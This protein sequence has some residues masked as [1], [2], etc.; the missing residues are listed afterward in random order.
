LSNAVGGVIQGF[1]TLN[2][3]VTNLG[4][5]IATNGTLVINNANSAIIQQAGTLTL[6]SG[7]TLTVIGGQGNGSGQNFNN[8]GQILAAG[9][10][11]SATNTDGLVNTG[12]I[13]GFGTISMGRLSGSGGA[14]NEII[15]AGGTIVATN[16]TLFLNPGDAFANGGFS[17]GV[18][19]TALIANGATLTLN[20]TANAWNNSGLNPRNRGTITLAGGSFVLFSDG[21]ADPSR[22]IDNIDGRISGFGTISG[23]ISNFNAATIRASGGVLDLAGTGKFYQ[24]GTLQVD[25]GATMLF[26]NSV[27]GLRSISNSGTIFMNGG[28]LTAGTITNANWIFGSGAITGDVSAGVVNISNSFLFASNG[29]L[30]ASLGSF[31]DGIG[32][33]MGTLSTDAVLNVQMPGGVSQPLIN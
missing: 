2:A 27:V 15:N 17:N 3:G 23:S 14:N 31:T 22:F 7:G 30:S 32:V 33:T 16:G 19:G 10:S 13:S 12:T 18:N 9:G 6:A 29:V 21:A 11:F 20:R 28:T 26:S 1:G 4:T 8:V 5:I 25:A 24:A